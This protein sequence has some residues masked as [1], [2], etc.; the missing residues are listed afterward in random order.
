[1]EQSSSSSTATETA[2]RVAILDAGSQYGKVIDRRV[3]ELQV[4]SELLP[5]NTPLEQLQSYKAIIISGGP[6]SVYAEKAPKFDRSLFPS[7]RTGLPPVLGICYGFQL[8]NYVYGGKVGKKEGLRQDGQT[9]IRLDNASPLFEGLSSSE[10]VLLTHGDALDEEGLAEGFKVIARAGGIVTALQSEERGLYGVQFHPEVDLTV[11]GKHILSN[12]LFK[13]AGCK[14]DYTMEDREQ[15]A[16]RE[17]Q[18]VLGKD[19]Q[20]LVLVSGGVDSAVCAALLH[21]ALGEEATTRLFALHVDHGF[22]RQ[23]ESKKVSE[24]LHAIGIPLKV[25][26]AEVLFANGVHHN[27]QEGSGKKLSEVVAPEEKRHIIGDMFMRVAESEIRSL[28]L[29][30][31]NVIL[32]QGTLRPDLIES[33]STLANKGGT[34]DVIKTHHNDTFLV[35]K[36]RSE[37]K[38]VEP[39]KD[40]H[41]DEVRMLGKSLGLPEELVWRQPFPGPGLAIRVICAEQPYLPSGFEELYQLLQRIIR[42]KDLSDEQEEDKTLKQRIRHCF[43]DPEKDEQVLMQLEGVHATILP[44]QSVGVQGD[45]RTYSLV[46]GLSLE[47]GAPLRWDHL[48]VLARLIPKLMHAVNRVCFIFGHPPIRRVI[49]RITPTHLTRD[50]LDQL[51]AA[52]AI[53]NEELLSNGLMRKLSQVPVISIP[54]SFDEEEGESAAS[55]KRSIVIRT[56]VTNDFMTGVAAVPMKSTKEDDAVEKVLEETEEEVKKEVEVIRGED[57]LL[58][59][60]VLLRMVE[61]ILN[62]VEGISRV[63]YDMTSKPPGTT[64]WE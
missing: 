52:D 22:M 58:G 49:R 28:G 36:L 50:V 59:E 63:C 42:F 51:R 7:D 57:C 21:K 54:L 47:E 5:F 6:A 40:Y 38:V 31:D 20:A 13:V 48:F 27:S 41:K 64:E 53:V 35:R 9:L 62:E 39:L 17:I 55:S 33:A 37:G 3:R 45:A 4:E 19:K 44:I 30:P 12:F 61:R 1:M 8:L 11:N 26:E 43:V 60:S 29:N 46:A 18:Q 24:A 14:A 56:M 2:Q 34:A 25:V 32:A 23:E 10:K 16:I 15:I